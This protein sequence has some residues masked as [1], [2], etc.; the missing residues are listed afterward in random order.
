[1]ACHSAKSP[2]NGEVQN[3]GNPAR[4][5]NLTIALAGNA[6]VGKSVVFNQLTG[7]SQ[8]IGNWPGK[9]VERAQGILNFEGQKVVVVDLPGIY[10]FS[11]FSM[12]EIVSREYIAFE[13]PDV[14]INVLDASVLERNLFFTIQLIEMDVPLVVC[15]NQMDVAKKKGVTI[16]RKKLEHALG[17]P[18]VS[19]VAIRGEGIYELTKTAV[20][21]AENRSNNKKSCL[22]YGVEIEERIEKLVDVIE[23]ENLDLGYPSRWVAI[24]LLENDP[25]IKK[26]VGSKSERTN[27]ESEVLAAEISRIHEE[28]CFAVLASERYSLA[29]RIAADAQRQSVVGTTLSEKLDWMTTHRVLGYITSAG[30]IV[31]LLLWT[32]TIGGSLSTLL[33]DAL[34]FFQPVNPKFN[35]SVLGVLWN[36]VFG[37][38]VAG[39]TLVVPYVVPFY[40]MLAIIEDSGVLTRVAFMMDSA[41]HKIGLHGKALIPLILGYG[42][43]VPAIRACRIMETKRERLLASFAVTFAPCAARTILILGL[44]AAFVS[45]FWAL[46]LYGVD[47]LL[48]FVLGR[49][50]LKIVPGQSTGLIMEMHSFKVPSLYVVGKQTWVRTKSLIYIVFPMYVIGSALVQVLYAMGVLGPVSNAILPLTVGWLGLPA[51]AG[52]LLILGVV[53]KEFILLGAVAIFGSTNLALFLTPVQLI[54]L[55]LI[56]I[57]YIPCLSTIAVLAKDFGWKTAAAISTANFVSAIIVGG[58][59]FRLLSLI[60]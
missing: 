50:A 40:M 16:D 14:V 13:H 32:F 27:N 54:T 51:I 31:G 12:E 6:N 35:G 43:N 44:V 5:G 9:T 58:I 25:E 55:A 34:G 30:V 3:R 49:I 53:R 42:C 24:K 21:V 38:I 20:K 29:N 17:V 48:I 59:A 4:V 26:L 11:T 56:G 15:L 46:A 60:L 39:I 8:I 41:M 22:R 7:S 52:I 57:L 28:P 2:E 36:G 23:S 45:P 37:G 1:M 18:V 47:I 19:T 33:S 10:S